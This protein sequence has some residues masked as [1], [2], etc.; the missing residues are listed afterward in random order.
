MYYWLDVN[1]PLSCNY[2]VNKKD[3]HLENAVYDLMQKMGYSVNLTDVSYDNGIDIRADLG[4]LEPLCIQCKGTARIGPAIMREA[5]GVRNME[6]DSSP[7]Y[8][9]DVNVV[10]VCPRGF[11]SQAKYLAEKHKVL[12]VDAFDLCSAYRGESNPFCFNNMRRIGS[13]PFELFIDEI[14]NLKK[15]TNVYI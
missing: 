5:V 12:I 15:R 11:S 7:S 6:N 4:D 3:Y 1:V 14:G 8:M 9:E 2:W 10:V 13:K